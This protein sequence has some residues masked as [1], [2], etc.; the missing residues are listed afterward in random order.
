MDGSLLNQGFTLLVYGMGTVFVFLTLLV[1]ATTI[2]SK[3]VAR[4]FP[5]LEVEPVVHS[6][7][8]AIE[9]DKQLTA[10]ISAAIYR[11]RSRNKNR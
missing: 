10:V 8:S 3:I 5:E 7:T 2:M 1:I 6:A 11:Y 4:L 9:S